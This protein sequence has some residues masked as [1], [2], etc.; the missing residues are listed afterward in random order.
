MRKSLLPIVLILL[1]VGGCVPVIPSAPAP[2]NT[3]PIATIDSLTATTIT[4]GQTVTFVGYGT[5]AGGTVVAYSWRSD[6]DGILSTSP[7]FS[8]STLSAGTHYI[9]FKV[10][11]NSGAWSNEPYRIVN[12]LPPGVIKPFVKSLKVVPAVIFE[13]ESTT[14]AWDVSDAM[15]VTISPDVGNVPPS[16]SRLLSPKM[17]TTYTITATNKAGAVTEEVKVTVTYV[18]KKTVELFSIASE[19]GY[20]SR[21]GDVGLEPKAGITESGMPMQAFFS[22]DISMIPQGATILAASIDMTP[23][24]PYG[25]P[26]SM[27]GAFGVFSDQY[28]A[29]E[30]RDYRIAFSLDALVL[31]YSQPTRAFDSVQLADA[32]QKQVDAKS[33][34]FQVRAQFEKF[35]YYYGQG[36]NYIDYAKGKTKLVIHYK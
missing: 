29:L 14:L 6:K 8:T 17:T 2:P 16:G 3:P 11:D 28:G 4:E 7:S 36:S 24:V 13:G 21:N 5:D 31:T 30:S 1:L 12:V 15:S 18:A 33:Q 26:F 34:R 22:F 20:V 27:L 9:Y 19:E 10:R 32:I 23:F 25:Y 35:T